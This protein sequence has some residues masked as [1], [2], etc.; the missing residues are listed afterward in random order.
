MK[1]QHLPMKK[2]VFRL[3]TRFF[4]ISIRSASESAVFYWQVQINF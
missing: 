2:A 1:K 3:D 4:S